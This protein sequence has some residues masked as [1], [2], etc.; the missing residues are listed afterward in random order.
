MTI[1]EKGWTIN[2]LEQWY[3]DWLTGFIP[4]WRNRY[5]V[6]LRRLYDIPFRVTLL[7]DENRVGDGLSMRSRYIYFAHMG[8]EERDIL[9]QQRPCSVLEV[10]IGLAQRFDEEYMTNYS[11]EYPIQTWFGHMI[12]S[13]GLSAYDDK[14]FD[15]YGFD[16]IMRNFLDRTYSPDGR[17]SLFYIPGEK[18]DMRRIEIWQQLMKWNK[19]RRQ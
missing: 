15:L 1:S 13:L 18:D 11:D 3:Y 12:E 14:H 4:E 9:R 8:A 6:L 2:T 10:M 17:G 16:I 5:S 7:M 19:Q